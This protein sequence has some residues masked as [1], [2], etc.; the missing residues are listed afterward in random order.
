[1]GEFYSDLALKMVMN[2]VPA[3]G[4]SPPSAGRRNGRA[5]GRARIAKHT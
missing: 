1:L 2:T 4:V 3:E 5:S